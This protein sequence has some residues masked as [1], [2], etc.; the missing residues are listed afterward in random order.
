M[1]RKNRNKKKRPVPSQS[2]NF[3][4]GAGRGCHI[5]RINDDDHADTIHEDGNDGKNHRSNI[6]E[7]DTE[8]YAEDFEGQE[9]PDIAMD[10]E[11][12]TLTLC[13]VTET[14]NV[15]YITIYEVDCFGKDGR[16]FESGISVDNEGN[17]FSCLTFIVLS[18]PMTFCT[19]CHVDV[20]DISRV[21]IESDVQEWKQHPNPSLKHGAPL[22]G[23]PLEG[24]PFLCTQGVGGHL[25]HYFSGNLHAID[26]R[27]AIGTSLLAVE[28]GIVMEA[29]DG[30]IC[31]GIGVSNMFKWN[32][33]LIRHEDV[34]NKILFFTEYVHIQSSHVQ[35]GDRV[36]RGDKIGLSGSVGFSPEPHL[37]FA[38]YQSDQADAVTV[39]F[40][41]KGTDGI[42]Y[43]PE[44]GKLYSAVGPTKVKEEHSLPIPLVYI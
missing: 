27:C 42:D 29:H 40:L 31:S 36:Q 41:F 21:R 1:P 24:G 15:A 5:V 7:W 17:S 30:N 25:T 35:K 16:K 20:D 10:P 6:L 3:F 11:N 39:G 23:F 33:I 19:L 12:N 38:V 34:D 32:S 28:D 8:I 18:P 9:I 26:F 44:A 14:I 13:N 43:Q 4:S 22:E 37:H 2:R